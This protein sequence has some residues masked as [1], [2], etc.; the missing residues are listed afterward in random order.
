MVFS[1]WIWLKKD[2]IKELVIMVSNIQ[3]G[4][5]TKLNMTTSVIK[6]PDSILVQQF[7]C[8]NKV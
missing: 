3:I 7:M 2:E 4:M 6:T 1:K 5:I 8:N